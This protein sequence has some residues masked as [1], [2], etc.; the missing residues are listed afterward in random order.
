MK[1]NTVLLFIVLATLLIV[2]S[3]CIPGDGTYTA[4][5]P[6]GFFWGFWHAIVA[7]VSLIIGL[8]NKHIRIYEVINSGWFY[9]F[10]YALAII[11]G[12]SGFTIFKNKN[13]D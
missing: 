13:R 2:F 5:N 10:G 4:G 6:A 11:C 12:V 7:P 3:G 8:F 9:D 1:K